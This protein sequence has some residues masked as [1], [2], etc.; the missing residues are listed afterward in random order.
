VSATFPLTKLHGL[1]NDFLVLFADALADGGPKVDDDLARRLCDRRR[2]VGA[3][4][5][6]VASEPDDAERAAGIDVVMRLFNADGS[7]AEMSGNG[8]RCLGHAVARARGLTEGPLAVATAAGRRDLWITPG[9][10]DDEVLVRVSMGSDR[11]GPAVPDEVVTLLGSR[12]HATADMGNPHLVVEVP[13][14]FEVDVALEG[15]VLEAHFADGINV[16][17]IA[18]T[19][20]GL[21]LTVWE[22]GAGITEACGTGACAATVVATRWGL[23]DGAARVRMPGGTT[24]VLLDAGQVVLTGPSERIADLEVPW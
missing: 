20:D 24:D 19:A 3:D 21:D 7:P 15:P 13:S 14:P 18:A 12:R 4:G 9:T 22:R 17:F 23:V 16:E 6:L 11:P 2:G 8:I 10:H 5:L 1:G